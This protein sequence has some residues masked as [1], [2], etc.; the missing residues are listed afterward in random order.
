[1]HFL[2]ITALQYREKRW[3]G[4]FLKNDKKLFFSQISE[5]TRKLVLMQW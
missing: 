3:I 2:E 1:M 4:I 5:C